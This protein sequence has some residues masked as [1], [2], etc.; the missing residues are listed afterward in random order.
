MLALGLT[1]AGL[2]TLGVHTLEQRRERLAARQVDASADVLANA[3]VTREA[4]TIALRQLPR[5]FDPLDDMEPWA[6]RIT[7]DLVFEGLV[8]RKP[9]AH[10]WIEPAIADRCYTDREYGVLNVTCHIPHGIRF[11]D[12][13]ELQVEDVTYSL[14]HWLYKKRRW[15]R[16]RQGLAH[17]VRV[18]VVDGPPGDRDHGRWVRM[19]F[20]RSEPLALEAIAAVK[21]VP[22]ELHRGRNL[23]FA[24]APIGTGPMRMIVMEADR[25]VL[26]RIDDHRDPSHRAS[27]HRIVF[28]AI[29]D[30]ADALAALRR[31]EVHLLPEV[32]PEHV[33]VELGEPGMLGRFDAYLVSPARYDLLLWNVDKGLSSDSGLREALD[34]ALPRAAIT[35]EVYGSP[36]LDIG[37]PLDL[38]DPTPLAL[39]ELVDI[40][41]GEPVRGGLLPMPELDSDRQGA[42]RAAA[43]L[44]KLDWPVENKGMRRRPGGPL[45]INLAWDGHA[46]RP[47]LLSDAVRAAWREV[48][49]WS[50]DNST[51]WQFLLG[52]LTRGDFRVA[53]L[54]FGGHHDEDLYHLFHSSGALNFSGVSDGQL[55]AALVAYRKAKVRAER[56]A[57]KR[58]IADRLEALRV[59]SMIHA[60]THVTLASRRLG[61]LDFVD[62]LPRLDRLGLSMGELDW[63]N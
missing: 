57:A 4:V 46:G 8:R 38:H 15:I 63:G 23:E 43:K 34:L 60:P 58:A 49:V 42:E 52:V 30:G 11:H 1:L 2:S 21:I 36:S 54:H 32:S 5:K 31:G 39:D 35:R 18:D 17:F 12:G 22:R 51:T 41:L 33:P 50:P 45:R 47:S 13:S 40:K 3:P 48:G 55:D 37:A 56:D 9:G 7:E 24:Q 10:P 26:E 6:E 29:N 53:L 44:D 28:R 25:I 61:E 16:Q 20:T 14:R 27:T 59:V 19:G 62:D